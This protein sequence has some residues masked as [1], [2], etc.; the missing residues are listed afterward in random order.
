MGSPR[1]EHG[2]WHEAAQVSPSAACRHHRR[3]Q[4]GREGQPTAPKTSEASEDSD[5]KPVIWVELFFDLVFVLAVTEV[6][7]LLRAEP[8]WAGAGRALLV[9]VPLYWAW[10]GTSVHTNTHDVDNPLD[11]VGVLTL[12]LCSLFMALAT[13]EAYTGRGVLFGGAYLALR[14]I[15]VALIWRGHHLVPV[16]FLTQVFITGPLLVVGALLQGVAQLALWSLAAVV[17]LATPMLFRELLARTSFHPGHLPERFSLFVIIL[18]GEAIVA[19]GAPAATAGHLSPG[20]GVAITVAFTLACVLGWIYFEFATP[21]VQRALAIAR[22]QTDIV[23]TGLSY[24][25]LGLIA[26]II[27]VASGLATVVASPGQHLDLTSASFLCG[28]CALYL[29]TFG[30]IR[31]RLSHAV[32]PLF[33]AGAS[34]TT[35]AVLPLATHT[36][37]LV[38]LGIVTIILVMFTV[39]EHVVVR[40][41]HAEEVTS[42]FTPPST[43]SPP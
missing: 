3:Q 25:H 42:T 37:A 38:A 43:P 7:A 29:A 17:D 24:A 32:A 35:L 2:P 27:A 40:R 4:E 1:D 14:A 34:L 16:P 20:T 39:L 8:S 6:S 11:R 28:G 22:V 30:V 41:T 15:L 18:L 5:D 33:P 31:A 10:I 19:V 36:S 12:G 26:A 9:F 13:L 21:I 23:R